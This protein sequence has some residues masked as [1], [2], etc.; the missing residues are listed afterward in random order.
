MNKTINDPLDNIPVGEGYVVVWTKI[1]DFYAHAEVFSQYVFEDE[2]PYPEFFVMIKWDGCVNVTF[3]HING[4]H[5]PYVHLCA[6]PKIRE[7]ADLLEQVFDLAKN[8][9]KKHDP[10][11]WE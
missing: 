8:Y 5:R 10:A 6:R 9:I 11:E 4:N 7:F 3:Q 1:R 2:D